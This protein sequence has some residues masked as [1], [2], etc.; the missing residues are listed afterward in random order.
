MFETLLSKTFL[1]LAGSLFFCYLGAQA[2]LNYFRKL[3]NSGSP[4]V[5]AVYNEKGQED[6]AYA[7][8][9]KIKFR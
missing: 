1:V 8:S 6:C 3:K 5:T 4:D 9:S 2:V 7:F